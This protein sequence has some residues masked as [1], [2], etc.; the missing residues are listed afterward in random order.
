MSEVMTFEEFKYIMNQIKA[1]SDKMERVSDFFEKELCTDSWCLVN[2][3]EDLAN[4]LCCMLA[5]HFSCW[6]GDIEVTEVNKIKVD[7]ML[8]D[9]GLPKS[10]PYSRDWWL[11]NVRR[12]DND[13]EYWLYEDNKKVTID[14]KEIPIDTL[15][16]F[17][18]YLIT[19][20]VDRK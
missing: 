15:E 10:N 17:Y 13:I 14:G 9:M 19:Y 4:T 5:D 16:Q 7:Q 18:N 11:P 20:C 2:V 6:W 3:G 1:H 8:Q 12:Y